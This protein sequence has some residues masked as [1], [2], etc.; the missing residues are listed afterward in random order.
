MSTKTVT[1]I[2]AITATIGI[3]GL[4]LAISAPASAINKPDPGGSGYAVPEAAPADT[5]GNL[6]LTQLSAGALGGIAVT[7][8][9]FATAARLRRHTPFSNSTTMNTPTTH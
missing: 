6:D 5:A 7:G 4:P 2:A 1:R 8:A 3:A 9:A